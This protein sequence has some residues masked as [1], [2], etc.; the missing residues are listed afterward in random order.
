MDQTTEAFDLE[1]RLQKIEEASRAL[2]KIPDAYLGPRGTKIPDIDW[3]VL[4]AIKKTASLT[5][6][7]C[8]LA[9]AKNTLAATAL[10]RLQLD[11]AL[12]MFG[13]SFI[14][15]LDAAGLHL[16]SDGSYQKLRSRDG[17]L[18][19]D[20]ML[21][22]ELDKHYP[23]LSAVYQATSAYVHLSSAHIKTGLSD[24]PG[25]PILYFH[26]N[27]TDN[28]NTDEHF[29]EAVDS[30]DQATALAIELIE[31]FVQSGHRRRATGAYRSAGRTSTVA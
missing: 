19:Q 27:G 3:F 5:H 2:V 16:M 11:T 14:D 26:L 28:S 17:E 13:L 12:R 25:S 10:I 30:F 24:R 31:G 7:F 23:G 21:H 29:A 18:L 22:R 9:R 8:T 15:D 20:G 6:A 4:A 1:A